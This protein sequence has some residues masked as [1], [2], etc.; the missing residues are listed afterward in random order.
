MCAE[1]V[2]IFVYEITWIVPVLISSW[3]EVLLSVDPEAAMTTIDLDKLNVTSLSL[4]IFQS[5]EQW[6]ATCQGPK[7]YAGVH[8]VT[9]EA[10][11]V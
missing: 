5:L 10:T 7:R 4:V 1:V 8:Q 2:H 6:D 9:L 11:H 3:Y